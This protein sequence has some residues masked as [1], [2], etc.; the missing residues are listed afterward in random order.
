MKRFGIGAVAGALL[1]AVAL[2][3]VAQQKGVQVTWRGEMRVHG[4]WFDNLTD[5][6]D[7]SGNAFKDSNAHYYQRWRLWTTV[8]SADKKARA[9]WGVEIG[10][11]VWGRGGGPSAGQFGGGGARIGPGQGA[12]AGND[13]VNIETK[14]LYLEFEVPGVKGAWLTMGGQNMSFMDQPI[15]GFMDDDF[16]GI[17]FR[18]KADRWDAEF[19]TAKLTENGL[20]EADD[21]DMYALRIGVNPTKDIRLTIE[22]MIIDQKC[23]ANTGN[24]CTNRA[25]TSFGDTA[26]LG[27]TLGWKIANVNVDLAAVWGQREFPSTAGGGASFKEDGYGI[28][29]NVRVPVGP[30]RTWFTAWYTSGDENRAP[31]SNPNA[32][33]VADSDKL[34]LPLN[35]SSSFSAPF[36][37]EWIFGTRTIGLPSV[38]QPLYGDMNGTYGIGGSGTFA[39]TPALSIGGGIGL[40]GASEDGSNAATP[41]FGDNVV[42]FDAGLLYTYNANL[43]FQGIVGYLIPDTGDNAYALGF[44]TRFA[45]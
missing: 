24:N 43:S 31:G 34:P 23:F 16:Y 3:A 14:H 8:E 7:T 17:K 19:Y 21:N 39:L 30:V 42:E 28:F 11:I 2:P 12:E 33:G 35:G 9:V 37:A 6:E 40:V 27:G 45:F 29:G 15:G 44:R 10:D 26:W 13:G 32:A 4:I 5:F 36:V 20:P 18:W 25:R 22:G 38:G 41:P 1:L